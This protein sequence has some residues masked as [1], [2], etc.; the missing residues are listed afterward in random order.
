MRP[1]ERVV[2]VG[3]TGSGKSTLGAGLAH[4][5]AAPLVELDAFQW[6]SGWTRVPPALFRARAAAALAGDRWVAVGNYPR[7]RDLTWRRAD[8]LVWLDYPLPVVF[9]RLWRRTWDE[10]RTG[11]D[12]WGGNRNDPARLLSKDSL[13]LFALHT[14]RRWRL[15]YPLML[16][17]P[18]AAHLARFRLRSPAE[19]EQWLA[20]QHGTH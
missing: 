16:A 19:A 14:H 20:G 6:G 18:G 11:R 4:R 13:F 3:T 15:A 9:A 10:L 17:E 1:V 7:H 5:L 8:T 2:V 12:A